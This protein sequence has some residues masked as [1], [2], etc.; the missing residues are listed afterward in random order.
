MIKLVV[1]DMDGTFLNDKKEFSE[2]FWEIHSKMEEKNIKFVVASGRQYQNLRKNFEKIMDKIVFIAENGSYV[3]EKEKEIYSRILSEDI[4]K[5]YVE[6]GRKIPT[7]NIVLCG[8]KSAYIESNNKEFI[9]EVEKY[10]EEKKIVTDLL[11]VKDDE[12]IKVTY[13]DL[14]GTEKNVYP[15]IKNEKDTQ[16]V[17]SG[18]IWLDISHLESNK[19][20]ALEALQKKLNIKYEET[21]IFGDYLNDYEMLKKGKYSFAMENAHEE[22]KRISNFIAK[23]NNENGVIEELKKII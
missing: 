2:E 15:Y 1:T 21:M 13:C 16:I 14:S 12:I 20:I 23:S 5:K 10:Y 6:I 9:N 4:I 3:V 22:V 11:E 8:K 7:T 19:G 17:V 18:E